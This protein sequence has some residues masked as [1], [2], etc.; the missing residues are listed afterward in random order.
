M[1]GA[2]ALTAQLDASSDFDRTRAVRLLLRHPLITSATPRPGVLAAVR[3][4]EAFLRAW[5]SE[6]LGYRLVV[7]HDFARLFKS[8]EPAT[9]PRPLRTRSGADFSP[10]QYSLL[11]LALAALEKVDVQTSLSALAEAVHLLSASTPGVAALDLDKATE[12]RGFVYALQAVAEHGCI[13]LRDGDEESFARGVAG[14]DALYDV[15]P[16]RLRQMIG[17]PVPPSTVAAPSELM[18]DPY[19]HT[20]EGLRRR[21]RHLLMRRLVERPV[22]YYDDLDGSERAYLRSQ[23][24]HLARQLE[25]VCGF[26]VETRAEGLAVI[27][28]DATASDLR[29]PVEGT[30]GHAALLLAEE[31]ARRGRA[32][33]GRPT[34][35]DPVEIE[36]MVTRFVGRFGRQWRADARAEGGAARLARE[37]VGYLTAFD[38]VRST[39]AG[40]VPQPAI[41]RFA[42]QQARTSDRGAR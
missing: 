6:W 11:C 4:H 8:C 26:S 12:R 18:V 10:R 19:P 40:I 38:L 20:D 17:A 41:A 25:E 30:L 31:L 22:L 15:H 2:A 3:R 1:S 42:P 28:D 23:R 36:R 29:W 21:T 33:E 32:S 39:D 16:H 5:F 37:A 24:H 35:E 9:P 7:E 14:A 34:P 27:D 13:E